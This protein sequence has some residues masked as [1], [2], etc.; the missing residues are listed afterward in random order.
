[1]KWEKAKWI[2]PV[3]A[4]LVIFESVL[5]VDRLSKQRR[6]KTSGGQEASPTAQLQPKQEEEVTLSLKGDTNVALGEEGEVALVM[7]PLKELF[8]DGID[9]LIQYDPEYL[10]IMGTDPSDRFSYLA[11]NWIEPEKKR[12]LVSMVETDKAGGV[13]FEP[14]EEVILLTFKYKSLKPGQTKLEIMAGKDK[15]VGTVLAENGTA[16]KIPFTSQDLVVTIK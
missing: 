8:L 14:G 13:R 3:L 7:R 9:L 5:I 6:S 2:I 16:N 11:R 12:I 1:M 4:V 15:K 10:E